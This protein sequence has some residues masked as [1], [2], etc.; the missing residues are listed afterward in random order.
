MKDDFEKEYKQLLET[1]DKYRGQLLMNDHT[2]NKSEFFSI[3][4]SFK[5]YISSIQSK[6][7]FE[8]FFHS[9]YFSDFKRFFTEK[10][11]YY[12]R[13]LEATS[14]LWI[15]TKDIHWLGSFD[16]LFSQDEIKDKYKLKYLDLQPFD[17]TDAHTMVFV[18]CWPM[19]E[20]MLYMYENT[21]IKRMIWLDYNYEAIYIAWEMIN[22]LGLDSI[23][24]VY[25]D[26]SNYDFS[27]ADII[28]IPNFVS[29]KDKILK[30]IVKTWKE[31]VQIWIHEAQ[32]FNRLLYTNAIYD[33]HP[34]LEKC[35]EFSSNTEYSLR[36]IVKLEKYKF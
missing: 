17:F 4:W 1:L 24:L 7:L 9:K 29:G 20:T 35:W 34:R 21:D 13:A 14:S 6:E 15:M 23:E 2:H 12:L 30:K 10:N 25:S 36:S 3:M 28:Y 18:W 5:K 33:L 32:L 31:S 11:N 22:N 8:K 27:D 26:W 16:L 19:P